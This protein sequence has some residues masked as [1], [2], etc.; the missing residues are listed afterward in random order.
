MRNKSPKT[1]LKKQHLPFLGGSRYVLLMIFV[2]NGLRLEVF[3][4][5]QEDSIDHDELDDVPRKVNMVENW[6][7]TKVKSMT[8]MIPIGYIYLHLLDFHGKC[9]GKY[10]SP[11]DPMG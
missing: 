5:I 3:E 2:S 7:S 11:M 1:D 9:I 4:A 6:K 10:T 8:I